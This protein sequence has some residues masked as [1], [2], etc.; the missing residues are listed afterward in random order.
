MPQSR[1]SRSEVEKVLKGTRQVKQIEVK[2]FGR[3]QRIDY[4]P[5]KIGQINWDNVQRL[6]IRWQDNHIIMIKTCEY[7]SRD[8]TRIKGQNK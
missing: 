1:I 6:T 5:E 2:Y 8:G 7:A 3:S 4:C